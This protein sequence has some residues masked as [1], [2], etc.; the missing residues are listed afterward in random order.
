MV[1]A[2]GYLVAKDQLNKKGETILYN[3]VKSAIEMI[4][5]AQKGVE[6][7]SKGAINLPLKLYL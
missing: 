4:H 5:I 3:S 6:T 2:L 7:L 1:G